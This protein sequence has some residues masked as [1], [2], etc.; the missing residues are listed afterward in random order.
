MNN[1]QKSLSINETFIIEA[2]ND[3]TMSACTGFFTNALVS[4]TGNTQIL[5]GNNIIEANSAFS[6]TTFY[7]DGSNLTGISTQ[8][9]FVTGGTY[10]TN[11]GVATFTNNTG[12][13]FSLTGFYTGAT[14]VYVTGVTF[15]N[16]L[17]TL[18]RNDGVSFYATI[19]DFV[20]LNVNGPL[21]AT[22]FYGD[23][24]NL[25][26]ISTQDTVVTG[27]T[28]YD[29]VTTF[30]N[31]TGGTFTIDGPSNYDA[32]I[33]FGAENWVDN[34]DGSIDLPEIKV[35]LYDN[36]DNLELL[37]I[38][39][40]ASGTTG[41]GG[42]PSLANNDTNYIIVEYNGGSP[43]Y[44]VLDN[45]GTVNS[46]D[47]VLYMI[48]YRANNF[49]HTLEFGNMG[50]GLPNKL[51]TRLISTDRFARE[52]GCALGLSGSTGVVTLSSGVVWNGPYRQIV[53]A[54]NSQDDVF[55][56][57]FH[58]GGTWTYVTTGDTINNSFYDDGTNLVSATA[59]KYLV[60]WYFRG[61]EVNDH[62]YELISYGQYDTVQLAEASP[63]PN[64]PELITSHAF[65]VGRIIVAVSATTGITQS[66]FTTVFQPSGAPVL[67]NDLAGIQGGVA[68]EYYHLDSNKYNN[69]AL[70]NTNNNFSVGQRFN[71]GLTA[72]TISATTYQNLP[73][74]I[75]VTGATKTG[76]VATF[77][78]N[79]GGT[80]TLTG[81]TDTFVTGGTYNSSVGQAT[82][83]NNT[84]G[85]FNVGGFFR[86][87][88]DIYVSGGSVSH[89][90]SVTENIL[91]LQRNNAAD[92]IIP[93]LVNVYNTSKTQ[94]DG[95]INENKVIRGKTYRI[96]DCDLSLYYNGT[97]E[98]DKP[99]YTTIYL[100][101]LENNKL[102]ETGVGVF[103]TPKY[104]VYDIFV[105]SN[106]YN[107][108]DIVIW[109][110]YVWECR[111]A[112]SYNSIDKLTLDPTGFE[113]IYPFNGNN[114][115]NDR[116]NINYDDIVYDYT[117]DKIIYR[118][119][120]NTNIVSTTT[121]NIE[122][123]VDLFGYNPI[124]VFQWG[125]VCY[126]DKDVL[127][128][129]G[130]QR[131]IN[132]YNENI[133]YT[134]KFQKDFYFN[135]LSYQRNIFVESASYQESFYFD[136][137]SY[138]VSIDF[139][140][141]AYQKN[142][143]LINSSYQ[144]NISFGDGYQ[145]NIILENAS[146]QN[147]INIESDS[148]Q[149]RITLKNG[150][151]LR[152]IELGSANTYQKNLNFDNQSYQ[153]VVDFGQ[154]CYQKNLNF[155][156]NSYQDTIYL[157]NNGK[158]AQ[159]ENID[160]T[161]N[162]YQTNI[163]ID[164]TVQQYFNFNNGYQTDINT[165]AGQSYIIIENGSQINGLSEAQ[166][167]I[168]IKGYNLDWASY[169]PLSP[170]TDLFF[171]HNLPSDTTSTL[172]GKKDN[173]LIEVGDLYFDGS[174]WVLSGE[175]NVG[176]I[177][178]TTYLGLPID[179]RVTGGTYNS[180]TSSITFTNNTGGTFSVTGITTGGGTSFT[181]GTVSGA[182]VFTNGL[183]ANTFSATSISAT[184][185]NGYTPLPTQAASSSGLVL[186]FVT[187]TV[188]GTLATPETG[189]TITANTVNGLLGVTNI[190]I[191]SGGTTPTF[192]SQYKKLSGSGNYTTGQINYIFTTYIT[193]TEII[194]SINQRT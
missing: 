170:Q 182:T 101:G 125:N 143:K 71:A 84:G 82:F 138:Q 193:S 128:G 163:T 149:D 187:D 34:G 109:G 14:D 10:N 88:D 18:Q 148:Y 152:N 173:R 106:V 56:K 117:N 68:G 129:I 166:D 37:K 94:M 20:S 185:Y 24:S 171:I 63:E 93:D 141:T 107:K 58:S 52:S 122:Y 131:I 90:P 135:N 102:S 79:S 160:F 145:T 23:G 83:R 112:G 114:E 35:A 111:T 188:Y 167:T 26:G 142:I 60:N 85:T 192:S 177:D 159:Q 46:S 136:N 38:Y 36:S 164:S 184:S 147:S 121:E 41:I 61:Q 80:F 103:Y 8:D 81:L 21:S 13:T 189:T 15:S 150:S 100:I 181:G 29:G 99:I 55:F 40:V 75:R 172:I 113:I 96:S 161:N 59:G 124:R 146:Y 98:G 42:I 95:V 154:E 104:G 119:E 151:Y 22:T 116:Y 49:V 5:L 31:N 123:W 118:N 4:C 45:D 108:N 186:S 153:D 27:G 32:G 67:H 65:L 158:L 69:L 9:I 54:V 76:N 140:K 176:T 43:I 179:V 33:I 183:T 194:Y 126:I 19:N 73:L 162:S 12:G 28:Y 47:V 156:N 92:V 127:R 2:E 87:A 168:T 115:L 16:N 77:R 53:T 70:T 174:K 130:D 175:I 11:T 144:S 51:N 44:N 120:Q 155:Y 64:L 133:N 7:G 6:A 169:T 78:N 110:G 48:V 91:T 17:L 191:H 30:T 62:L 66:A 137:G 97:T 105:E 25:T 134:G 50:A 74:D 165:S 139:Q 89:G 86:P 157:Q 178:A 57:S 3:G 1:G 39:T 180:G 132:S 190:I 72:T